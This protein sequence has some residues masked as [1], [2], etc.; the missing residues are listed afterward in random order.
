[1]SCVVVHNA[2]MFRGKASK[3]SVAAR[4]LARDGALASGWLMKQGE[5]NKAFK[6][7]FSVLRHTASFSYYKGDGDTLPLKSVD[8]SNYVAVLSHNAESKSG[9]SSRKAPS[10]TV[11]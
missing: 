1:M 3:G 5:G 2:V 7:R 4:D 10:T 9:A 8:A 11:A 6:K